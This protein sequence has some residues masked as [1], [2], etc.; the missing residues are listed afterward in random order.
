MF[1]DKC[2]SDHQESSTTSTKKRR[3]LVYLGQ[4]A[5]TQHNDN[6]ARRSACC[7][8]HNGSSE[9]LGTNRSWVKSTIN[10]RFK[11]SCRMSRSD[12]TR[13]FWIP[14]SIFRSLLEWPS[15]PCWARNANFP[16]RRQTWQIAETSRATTKCFW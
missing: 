13:I 15:S 10:V 4:C 16:N 8:T 9:S 2:K 14:L 12:I 7:A 3:P 1:A 6:H 11:M 5:E